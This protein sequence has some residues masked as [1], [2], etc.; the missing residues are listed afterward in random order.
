MATQSLQPWARAAWDLAR[1][2]HFV[3]TRAQLLELGLS[4]G[5][6]RHRLRSGRL[7]PVARGVYAVG[8][9]ELT[10]EGRWMAAVLC[11][12]EGAMLSHWSA[13]ALWGMLPDRAGRVDV[14]IPA[15][16]HVRRPEVRLHRRAQRGSGGGHFQPPARRTQNRIPVTN[17]VETLVDLSSSEQDDDE[18]EEAV[19]GADRLGLV[20][21][22]RL[23]GALDRIPARSGT[24]RLKRLLDR[25]TFTIT[26][27]KLERR[28]LPIVAEAGLPRPA[29]QVRLNGY[30][31]DFHWPELGLVVETDGLTYHRTPF[32]QAEDLRRDQAHQMAGLQVRRFSRDQVYFEPGYVRAVLEAAAGVAR[33]AERLLGEGRG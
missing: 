13:A 31:V 15:H 14:L 23:R 22:N 4:P 2:Q 27:T 21:A 28:F 12:G 7:H 16:R 20:K 10:R 32:S 30:R 5:A 18:I 9:A 26:H 19:G 24:G 6:I 29:S 1:R 8:R 17:P 33:S 11:C 25:P 3:V